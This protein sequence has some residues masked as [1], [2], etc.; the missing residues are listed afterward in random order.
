LITENIDAVERA[1][2]RL[3]APPGKYVNL[4]EPAIDSVRASDD[5]AANQRKQ[6]RARYPPGQP[7][8]Q[9]LPHSGGPY[10]THIAPDIECFGRPT[11]ANLVSRESIIGRASGI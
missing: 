11:F 9:R 7:R 3:N 6:R 10:K 1:V 4:E 5:C 2:N 8:E